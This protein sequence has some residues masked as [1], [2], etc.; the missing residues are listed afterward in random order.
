MTTARKR[1]V[2][3]VA[4]SRGSITRDEALAVWAALIDLDPN[5]FDSYPRDRQ[6]MFDDDERVA[7]VREGARRLL[8]QM[9]D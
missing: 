7:I 2:L 8:K 4:I 1:S 9:M 6:G 3:E 5:F